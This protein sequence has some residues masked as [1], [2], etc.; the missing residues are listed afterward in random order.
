MRYTV[1]NIER[2]FTPAE[3][4]EITGVSTALQ[5][6]WRRRGILAEKVEGKWTRWTLK[7]VIG[8]AVMKRLS[9]AGIDVSKTLDAA[10]MAVLPTFGCIYAIDGAIEITGA[11]VPDKLLTAMLYADGIQTRNSDG[12]PGREPGHYL[13]IGRDF[14][15]EAVQTARF[16]S[17]AGMDDF[18]TERTF[19]LFLVL[20]CET[21]GLEIFYRA[22]GKPLIRK[23]IEASHE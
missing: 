17:L 2:E 3:A 1:R 13:F 4:A 16:S 8:L 12:S 18:L 7:D 14:V 20:D 10:A 21:L 22:G 9:D 23:E 15:S 5:R 6:D 11:K 19:G